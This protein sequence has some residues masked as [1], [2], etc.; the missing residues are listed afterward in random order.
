MYRYHTRVKKRPKKRGYIL[1]AGGLA[2]IAFLI[3]GGG[4]LL[5]SGAEPE[6]NRLEPSVKTA[7]NELNFNLPKPEVE[8]KWPAKIQSAVGAVGYGV[9]AESNPT[10]KAVPMASLA[11][12][13]AAIL[14]IE[15]DNLTLEDD[16]RDIVFDLEDEGFYNKYLFEGGVVTTVKAGES[17]T[18]RE[19]LNAMLIG[20]S[21][22]IADTA[23]KW[24]FGSID[25]YLKKANQKA[26]ELGMNQTNFD[27]V[28]G[29]S[30]KSAATAGNLVLL[31][32]YA[33]KNSL[34]AEIVSTWQTK[35]LSD[36]LITNTNAFLD[37]ENNGVIGIKSGLTDEAGGT[38]MT[39]AHY[40]TPSG[41]SVIA[42]AVTLGAQN[43]FA[44]QEAA[45][46]LLRSVETGFNSP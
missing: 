30:P 17:I 32:E 28:A 11:K 25:N 12:V 2:V 27:D 4:P 36:V 3:F 15:T 9:I 38:F 23:V 35:I 33:M 21:N 18:Q 14:I 5:D 44:A 26:L 29:F 42:L 20:S 16:G 22:N 7:I 40:Q 13:M 8:P 43:H 41:D 1:V 24:T 39:A 10:A 45:I 37:F 46:P 6:Q 34:F 19:A 31:G